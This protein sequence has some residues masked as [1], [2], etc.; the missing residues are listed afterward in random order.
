M[1]LTQTSSSSGSLPKWVLEAAAREAWERLR[2]V[3]ETPQIDLAPEFRGAALALQSRD[4][5]E[6]I[7]SGPADTGKTFAALYKLNRL[8]S[9]YQGAQFVIMRKQLTDVYSTCLQT[10]VEK[11]LRTTLNE[12]SSGQH[13]TVRS[14][15]GQKPEWFDYRA[16]GARIWVGGIDHPGKALSAERDGIYFNQTEEA[17][18]DDWETL[19]TRASGRAGHV[20][21]PQLVGDCNPGPESHWIRHR[22][23]LTLLESRHEDNPSIF[24]ADGKLTPSGVIRMAAL[25]SLTGLR[26]K[27]LRLGLWVS[28]EGVVYEFTQAHQIEPFAIPPS[29]KRFRA[30]DFGYTHPFV[31]GW[32]AEDPD[33]RLYLYRQIYMTGR[34][35]RQ[36]SEDIK[37]YSV[38]ENIPVTVCDHDA[39]DMAT[40]RENGIATVKADKRVRA[41]IE[42]V[43]ERLRTAKDGKPRFLVFKDG[44]VNG[45]TYGLVEIDQELA[46]KRKPIRTEQEFATYVWGNHKIKDEPVKEDD[47]GMDMSRYGVMYRDGGLQ[48]VVMVGG[49][50]VA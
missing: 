50:R 17:S 7:I 22:G 31:C 26:Y 8:A 4:D 1:A 35:V 25:D 46:I 39:E 30:I 41:G 10:Y 6:V 33:G 44:V 14:Y 23:G 45:V 34:T 15:G 29:W 9:T 49:K 27:R 40:L 19:V 21:L 5:H 3:P 16:T 11:V 38:G 13:Q 18:L 28:A 2:S 20:P 43:E 12:L 24:A 42:K 48:S 32:F 47:H 36:H 37:R